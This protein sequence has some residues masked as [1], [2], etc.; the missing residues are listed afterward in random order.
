M[1]SHRHQ[2]LRQRPHQNPTRPPLPILPRIPPWPLSHP[3][4]P[5][6]IPWKLRLRQSLQSLLHRHQKSLQRWSLRLFDR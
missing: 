6:R 3:Q 4:N 1:T 2:N 5:L